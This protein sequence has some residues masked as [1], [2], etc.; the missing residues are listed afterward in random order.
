MSRITFANNTFEVVVGI[1]HVTS[2][3]IQ[4]FDLRQDAARS[5]E[6]DAD[7]VVDNQGVQNRQPIPELQF[8]VEKM[9]DSFA[10]AKEKG[11]SHPN[12]SADIVCLA[13]RPL[14]FGKEQVQDVYYLLMD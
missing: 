3:F 11:N 9:N 12:L 2:A 13:I 1:D 7:L 10:Y 6:R 4:V 8:W 5:D 14:G